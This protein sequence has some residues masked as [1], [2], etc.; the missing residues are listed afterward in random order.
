MNL[1]L[2]ED[3]PITTEILKHTLTGALF[4]IRLYL[5]C[6]SC[7]ST[8]EIHLFFAMAETI[9]A[10]APQPSTPLAYVH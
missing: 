3:D 5:C 4:V 10:F 7:V 8:E 1:L 9:Y 6:Y 2:I